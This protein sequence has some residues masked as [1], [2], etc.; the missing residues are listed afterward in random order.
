MCNNLKEELIN[1]QTG[2]KLDWDKIDELKDNSMLKVKPELWCEWDFERNNELGL[3]IW[4]MTKAST[5]V[6]HWICPVYKERY[7]LSTRLKVNQK[8]ASLYVAGIRVCKGNS[9]ET[10]NPYLSSQWNYEKNEKLKP[11]DVTYKASIG[12][13]WKC[14]QGHEW[15][16][17]IYNR[18]CG[19]GCPVCSN[20]KVVIGFNNIGHTNPE[21]AKYLMN[22]EDSLNYTNSSGEKV[23]WKCSRC[24]NIIKNKAIYSVVDV[25]SLTCVICSKGRSFGEK[26]IFSL[27][28]ELNIEFDCEKVFHWNSNRRYDYVIYLNDKVAI[29][30]IHGMQHFKDCYLNDISGISYA[31]QKI[32]DNEKREVALINK[33]DKYFELDC[34]FSDYEYFIKSIISS[35]FLEFLEVKEESIKWHDVIENSNIPTFS[36][37]KTLWQ[38]GLTS[39]KSISEEL[40]ISTATVNKYLKI[41]GLIE[42]VVI[43]RKDKKE[44]KIVRHQDDR[45]IVQ[46][47]SNGDFIKYWSNRKE[48]S[49]TLG[50]NTTLIHRCLEGLSG[51]TNSNIWMYRNIYDQMTNDEL[52][53]FIDNLPSANKK[54][55]QLTL[56]LKMIECFDSVK[57]ASIDLKCPS[58]SISTCLKGKTKTYRGFKWMYKED[59]EK[60]ILEQQNNN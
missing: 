37:I 56:D 1:I 52:S 34:R 27:L 46:L 4:K 43:I 6:S 17:D 29:A 14:E 3:D 24:E 9:L 53:Y 7:K 21:I 26:F 5:V 31:D 35:G 13:W 39:P 25:D 58:N 10:I 18:Y 44:M 15:K 59:Y 22:D 40:K 33:I 57:Q 55:I 48:A 8:V 19:N 47:N 16:A 23:D 11:S 2:E 49:L 32:I 42:E 30:E 60:M 54:V 41:A 50:I 20:K 51:K 36:M 28:K 45:E 38:S 12:V